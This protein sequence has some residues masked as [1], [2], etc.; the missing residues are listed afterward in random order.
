MERKDTR[1]IQHPQSVE[2]NRAPV[3]QAEAKKQASRLSKVQEVLEFVRINL[4]RA[5]SSQNRYYNLRRRE[6]RC[7]VGDKVVKRENHLSSA[8]KNFAAKLATKYSGPFVVI[9][10]HL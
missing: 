7:L 4:S 6:W 10:H 2:E 5:Y 9:P 8:I 1:P 3:D